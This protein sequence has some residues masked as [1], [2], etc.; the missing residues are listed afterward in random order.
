MS[1]EPE[2]GDAQRRE[3]GCAEYVRTSQL[4]HRLNRHESVPRPVHREDGIFRANS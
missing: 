3:A 2:L 1:P 4:G